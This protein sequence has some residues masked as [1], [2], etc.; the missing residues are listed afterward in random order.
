MDMATE[1]KQIMEKLDSIQSELGSMKV[2]LVDVDLVLTDDDK[3][4][5]QEAEA[6]LKSRKTV[7]L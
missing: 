1:L 7:R 3:E 6:D 4:A 5:L 2:H